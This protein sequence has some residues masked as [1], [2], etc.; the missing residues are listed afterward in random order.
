MKGAKKRF[1]NALESLDTY[2]FVRE[3]KKRFLVREM[4]WEP[5][6]NCTTEIRRYGDHVELLES[7]ID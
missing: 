6:M 1:F 4:A 3:G 7:L 2:R 5:E